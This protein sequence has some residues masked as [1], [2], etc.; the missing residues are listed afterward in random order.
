M[1][2]AQQ[3]LKSNG[4]TLGLYTLQSFSQDYVKISK[5]I[6]SPAI[7]V[8]IKERGM[9]AVIGDVSETKLLQTFTSSSRAGG[10]GSSSACGG[11]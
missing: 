4:I 2:A 8:A 5:Q 11:H 1:L 7:L 10:C 6:Q 9:A 3:T